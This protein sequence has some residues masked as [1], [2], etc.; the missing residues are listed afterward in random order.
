MSDEIEGGTPVLLPPDITADGGIEERHV[1]RLLDVPESLERF[2]LVAGDVVVVRQGTLG[3]LALVTERQQQWLYGSACMRLRPDPSKIE[4]AYLA[5]Y[6]L[7]PPVMDWL[8]ARANPGT[9]ITV[10]A[11]TMA[12][13]PVA[14][15]TLERQRLICRTLGEIDSQLVAQRRLVDRLEV[16]RPA[17]FSDFLGERELFG[18]QHVASVPDGQHRPSR[19]RRVRR[20]S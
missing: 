16:M 6:L 18:R 20:L 8:R 19:E 11:T 2:R 10:N 13:L 4:P 3:K 12:Q 9:V 1:R 14:A 7:H 15:P 5:N 17:V